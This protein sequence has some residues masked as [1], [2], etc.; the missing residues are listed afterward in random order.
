M[1][2][3]IKVLDKDAI[4][5][6][7]KH[8]SFTEML[9][10]ISHF[11]SIISYEKAQRILILSENS[12]G[13]IYAFYSILAN[14]GIAV[15]V[16]AD[17]TIEDIS[18]IM[19]D[20]QPAAMWVS[21]KK[22]QKAIQAM[23]EAGIEIPMFVIDE[24]ESADV[25]NRPLATFQYK[26][27]DTC[28][29]CYTSGTTGAAKG[30]MLSYANILANTDA[31]YKHVH[32]Y[33]ENRRT[34]ILLPL[35]HIL[36]LGG[37]CLISFMCGGGVAICQ[38]LSA[39]KLMQALQN[40][41]V[42]IVV[43]VPRLWQMLYR[44]IK[45]KID[46]NAITRTLFKICEKLQ[47]RGLS[48][49]VFKSVRDKMGGKIV[50][51]VSAGAALDIETGKGL[52]TLGLDVL[53]G[54]GMTEAAPMITFT[55]PNDIRPGCS[56][57]AVPGCEVKIID[58][59]ICYRGKNVMQGYY[60]R[61]EE[62]AAIFDSEGFLHSGDLGVMDS[63]GHLTVTGRKKDIIV[64][65]NGKNVN[66]NELEE[67]I[68]Q[69]SDYVKEVG[70]TYAGDRLIAI[71]VPTD[72][73]LAN[74]SKEEIMKTLRTNVLRPYNDSVAAYKQIGQLA[75]SPNPLPRTRLEKLQR[76]KLQD[77]LKSLEN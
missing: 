57:I 27:E 23:A 67:K 39:P 70:V 40:G 18:Y 37:T 7:D 19:K 42:S 35:H 29:I 3:L 61:P 62:T 59:E 24:Y 50:F 1:T 48:R 76:Y 47:W 21:K 9:Q 43:G 8:I 25:K 26:E 2:E 71:V 63:E 22:Q 52:K 54:Y 60:G 51:L 28:I 75:I 12:E 30:A 46:A 64:L 4:I 44:G 38:S 14:G 34:L 32:I 55:R 53:E 77:I 49:V 72:E 58:G 41:Q 56:G 16:D 11:S 31:V 6:G 20:C 68:E 73:M 65:S 33:D 66:P 36:S 13:W 15:P 45:A 17:G 69:F 74:Q 5:N 10:H